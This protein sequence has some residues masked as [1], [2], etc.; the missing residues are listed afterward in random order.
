LVVG[1]ARGVALDREVMADDRTIAPGPSRWQRAWQA[2]LRPWSAWVWPAT[3]LGLVALVLGD[4][5]SRTAPWLDPSPGLVAPSAWLG[6]L[7]EPLVALLVV[8]G[9]GVIG[10]AVLM[11]QLGGVSALAQRRLGAPPGRPAVLARLGLCL[12]VGAGVVL[13]L[14]GVLAGAAR[15]VDASEAGI[16]ALWRGWA[17]RAGAAL[18]L[19]LGLGAVVELWLDRRERGARL[20]QSSQQLRD[21]ARAAGGRPR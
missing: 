13:A 14:D 5:A 10:L 15:A 9:L 20:W 12:A 16:F 2:G 4:A 18:S 17:E 6:A 1:G 21:E 7:V 3:A 11:R 8:A 19:G